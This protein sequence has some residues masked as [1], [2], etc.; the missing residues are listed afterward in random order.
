MQNIDI[1][2]ISMGDLLCFVKAVECRSFTRAAEYFHLTQ[3]TVSKKVASLEQQLDLQ[4]FIRK[5]KEIVL[6][7][8]G[9]YLYERWKELPNTLENDLQMAHTLKHGYQNKLT[10]GFLNSFRTDV[11]LEPLLDMLKLNC[12][13]RRIDVEYGDSRQIQELMLKGQADVVFTNYFALKGKECGSLRWKRYHACPSQVCMRKE[14]PLAQKETLASEDLKESRFLCI[15]PHVLPEYARMLSELG[16]LGG[17]VPR[18]SKHL[19]S[20]A[21]LSMNLAQ[22]D[23]VF[24]CDDL[25]REYH[26]SRFCFRPLPELESGYVMIWDSENPR[27]D[28]RSLIEEMA[29]WLEQFEEEAAGVSETDV[30]SSETEPAAAGTRCG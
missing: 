6:T 4:L 8:A 24:V 29:G 10:V 20:A 22:P 7:D 1:R 17:F 2:G 26:N 3:S 9:E 30:K 28:I 12:P 14:H 15:A 23:E 11:F 18:I 16:E 13:K 19:Y 21:A 5:K 27:K 25:Y